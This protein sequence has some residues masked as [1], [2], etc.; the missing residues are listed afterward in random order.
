MKINDLFKEEYI[1]KKVIDNSEENEIWIIKEDTLYNERLKMTIAEYYSIIYIL[2]LDFKIAEE[3]KTGWENLEV[4][5]PIYF[6]GRLN[7][8]IRANCN[9]VLAEEMLFDN[10]NY[11]STEEKAEEVA[12]FQ[13]ELRKT[14]KYLDTEVD[15][16]IAQDVKDDLKGIIKDLRTNKDFIKLYKQIMTIYCK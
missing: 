13:L 12:E 7:D 10:Y 14:L 9:N 8:C 11:F 3:E 2:G 6:I 1:G 16:D 5:Q 15:E 4:G